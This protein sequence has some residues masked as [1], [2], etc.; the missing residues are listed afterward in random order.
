M[1]GVGDAVTAYLFVPL[2]ITAA[3][4]SAPSPG[5]PEEGWGEGD[6]DVERR[7]YSKSPS[8]LPSPG[9]PGEG[10]GLCRVRFLSSQIVV[11]REINFGQMTPTRSD[12]VLWS[13]GVL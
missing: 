11:Q 6:L 8:P 12:G 13:L 9:V 3:V 2:L 5:I 7:W 1:R 10:G 4:V